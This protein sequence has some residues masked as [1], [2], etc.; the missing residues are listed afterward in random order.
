[1]HVVVYFIRDRDFSIGSHPLERN[2]P[3]CAQEIYREPGHA[4]YQYEGNSFFRAR[5][6]LFC[7]ARPL[8]T[9]YGVDDHHE[10]QWIQCA[11]KLDDCHKEDVEEEQEALLPAAFPELLDGE[12]HGLAFTV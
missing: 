5:T 9:N 4:V 7:L 2:V 1:M 11:R 8:L 3:K 10:Y 12:A 6:F